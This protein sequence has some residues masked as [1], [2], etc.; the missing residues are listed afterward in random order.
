MSAF[1]E[2]I[3][4]MVIYNNATDVSGDD[5]YKRIGPMAADEI[6]RAIEELR[7]RARLHE[8][9]IRDPLTTLYNRRYL[10]E[11]IERELYRARKL[12]SQL[13]LLILD[14]DHFKQFNDRHGH[15]GG[16][17]VLSGFGALLQRSTRGSDIACRY[18][19]E[20]FAVLMPDCTLEGAHKRAEEIRL[21]T[22]RLAI[23]HAGET[24]GKVTVSIGL[25]CFSRDGETLAELLAA[26]DKAL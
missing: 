21:G 8:Q 24:L 15:S 23:E 17:H 2:T 7:L 1:G 19:G 5:G 12:N 13:C 14:L 18:G 9:S 10:M 11:P 6:A 16:D 4:V 22:A 25:A 3:G 26:A 20:E